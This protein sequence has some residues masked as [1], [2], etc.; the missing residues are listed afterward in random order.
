MNSTLRQICKEQFGFVENANETHDGGVFEA[1]GRELFDGDQPGRVTR[2]LQN[3][4]HARGDVRHIPSSARACAKREPAGSAAARGPD[5]TS[6]LARGNNG[7]GRAQGIGPGTD[8]DVRRGDCWEAR[9]TAHARFRGLSAAMYDPD[10]AP[11]VLIEGT[12]AGRSCLVEENMRVGGDSRLRRPGISFGRP[13]VRHAFGVAA[14]VVELVATPVRRLNRGRIVNTASGLRRRV[15]RAG[16]I[17]SPT[18]SKL[19]FA[20]PQGHRRPRPECA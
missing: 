3:D 10:G 15:R 14:E 19:P 20:I 2:F 12:G 16:R 17:F 8:H 11:L 18:L 6:T 13:V 5:D 1:N 9:C 7:S 4:L